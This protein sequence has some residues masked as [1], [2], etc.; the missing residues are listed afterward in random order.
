MKGILESNIDEYLFP[1]RLSFKVS[2][3]RDQEEVK[4]V[5]EMRSC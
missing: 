4:I 5:V 3:E 1:G 2:G